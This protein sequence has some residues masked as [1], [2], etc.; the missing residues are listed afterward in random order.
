MWLVALPKDKRIGRSYW[1]ARETSEIEAASN[2]TTLSSRRRHLDLAVRLGIKADTFGFI[3]KLPS[4]T[5]RLL[6]PI[7]KIIPLRA[8]RKQ[9]L[10]ILIVDDEELVLDL[11]EHHLARAGYSVVKATSGEA[12][13]TRIDEA[14]PSGVILATMLPGMSGTEV[15]KRIRETPLSRNVPVLV[16]SHRHSEEDIVDA[17]RDGASDYLT[18]PFLIG[19]LLER[20]SKMITPYEHPLKSLLDELAA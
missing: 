18:K 9:R 17:L 20:V 11:L 1:L 3:G 19:E 14:L 15:L 7:G 4:V 10:Q 16:L 5:K 13:L 2:A 8:R 12:A 6:Q